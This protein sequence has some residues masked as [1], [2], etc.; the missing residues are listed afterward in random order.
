MD[1]CYAVYKT[2]FTGV[3]PF[4]YD[5][6]ELGKYYLA[7][8]RLMDHWRSVLGDAILDISYEALVDDTEL[9]TKRLLEYCGLAWQDNCLEFHKSDVPS[10]TASA[11]QVRRPI[12]RSSIG[13]WRCYEKQLQPLAELLR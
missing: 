12:Y 3:Y 8:K 5:L 7:Y 1:T 11:A 2:F 10:T 9:Q 6:E 4:S 13:R